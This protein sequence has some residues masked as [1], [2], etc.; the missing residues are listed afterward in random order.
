MTEPIQWRICYTCG[1]PR[2]TDEFKST[3]N[4]HKCQN[5]ETRTTNKTTRATPQVLQHN[6]VTRSVESA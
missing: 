6:D 1:L 3:P 2:Y 4:C 5:H